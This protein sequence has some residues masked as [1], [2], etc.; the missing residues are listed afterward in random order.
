MYS[1]ALNV[2]GHSATRALQSWQIQKQNPSCNIEG[3][4][5]LPTSPCSRLPAL[6]QRHRQDDDED[7]DHKHHCYNDEEHF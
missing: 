2:L 4:A 3:Q 1:T 6:T 7:D 5:L